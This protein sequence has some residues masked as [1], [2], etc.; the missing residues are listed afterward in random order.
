MKKQLLMLGL[1]LLGSATM[2]AQLSSPFTGAQPSA[3]VGEGADYYLYNVKSGKWLQNNDD[4]AS[5]PPNNATLWTTRAEVGTRGIDWEV[6]C[7]AIG[8]EYGNYYQLNPKFGKNHSMNASNLYLDTNAAVTQWILE[9]ADNAGVSNAFRICANEGDYPYLY[10]GEDGWIATSVDGANDGENDV[11][12]LVTKEQRLEYMKQQAELNGSADATW[13]IGCPTFA[14]QDTRINNWSRSISIEGLPEGAHGPANGNTG[15][16][17][18]NCN[19]VFEMWSSYSASLTQT[20]KDLPV[21]TY[22]LS[23]QG[24]YREGSADNVKDWDGVSPFGYDLWSTGTEHHYAKYFA[25]STTADIMSIFDGAK[26]AREEGYEYN[27]KMTDPEFL[28]VMESGKWVPNSTDQASWA[29]FYGAYKNPEIKTSVADGTLNIGVKKEQGVNDDWIIVDN[30]KLTYYGSSIDLDQ[31]KETL[32]QAIE[33]GEAFTARS[34]DALNKMFDDAMAE[35]RSVYETSSDATEI[36]AAATAITTAMQ[37]INETSTNASFLKQTVALAQNEKVEGEA[38]TTAADVAVNGVTADAINSALDNLRMARRLNAADRQENKF[39]GNVPAAGSFY[40]YNVGQKR[41]FCGGED[42][43]AHAALGFPGIEVTLVATE[44]EG[45][46]VIDT[47][48]RNGENEHY[49]GYNGYCDVGA[50]DPWT[51]EKV[52]E[53]VYVIKRTNATD[54]QLAGGNVYLGYRPGRYSTVDTDMAGTDVADNQWILVTKADRDA[55]LEAASEENPVDAS[56]LIKMPNF[57]QREYEITGGWDNVDG[58]DYAWEHVNG[59]IYGRTENK[60]DF[61]FECFNQDPLTLTQSIYDMKAGYY[62]L[63]VQGYYRDC[64]EVDYTQSIAAGGYEPQQNAELYAYDADMN[65]VSTKLVTI[66]KYANY[67]PG[68]GWNSNTSVG[69]IPNNPDQ[70]INYFQVGAYKN[71]LLVKVG[72]DGMLSFGISKEN[73]GEKDWL[74]V[75]NFRLTY[76]GE[77]TPTGIDGVTDNTEAVKDGKIYNLQGVQVKNA[78]QRGVYIK[79]GKKFVVE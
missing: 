16:G 11:W 28:D 12:Q 45:A 5:D 22:G 53:G 38:M 33:S 44:T 73:G 60:T 14:N 10:V 41:F 3:V 40:L 74:C 42:W 63:S 21:G 51:F 78:T 30:F 23:V 54:E 52:S 7:L 69:W 9:P 48:L 31:V 43:G 4:H 46:F 13:L 62:I 47:R 24:Y 37:L 72:D 29:L 1:G 18:I 26:D 64:T 58:Q 70:A 76:L 71:S 20:I 59:T 75:D 27:A 2:S 66:E 17:K 25:N 34:T 32:K 57:N 50:Q 65:K 35:G 36:G 39:K 55:L 8:D 15:D 56:Y 19:R 61:A 79:N 6:T 49:L 67:A 77:Q 68:Y